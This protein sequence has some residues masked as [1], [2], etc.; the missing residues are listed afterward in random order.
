ME[1]NS[2]LF[3]MIRLELDHM[4]HTIVHS[5]GIAGT[6][7]ECALN[8]EIEKQLEK[9]LEDEFPKLIRETIL[10]CTQK[11]VQHYLHTGEVLKL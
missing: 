9:L 11:A 1:I 2:N 3:P 8:L 6:E 5:M 4:K 7:F 10:D